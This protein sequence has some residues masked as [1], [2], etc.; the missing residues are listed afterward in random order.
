MNIHKLR[1]IYIGNTTCPSNKIGQKEE[2]W[3]LDQKYFPTADLAADITHALQIGLDSISGNSQ[4]CKILAS[5]T[6][7]T[8][9]MV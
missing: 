9:H 3:Y 4:G 1:T 5:H 2:A 6:D 8:I 7:K